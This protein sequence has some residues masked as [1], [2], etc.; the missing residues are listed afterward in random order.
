MSADLASLTLAFDGAVYA[1]IA[2][3]FASGVGEFWYLPNFE[4]Y[5]ERFVDHP[6][7]GIY[8]TSLW[9]QV[10]GSAFWT[11]KLLH[12]VL[13]FTSVF[14]IAELAKMH[15]ISPWLAVL[16]FV[17]MPQTTATF[18]GGYLESFVIT[19]SLL[20]VWALLRAWQSLGW[21][22]IYG[23]FVAAAVL[24]KGPVGLFT[25]TAPLGLWAV[26]R[27]FW[28]PFLIGCIALVPLLLLA[29][30]TFL[31]EGAREFV[32]QY[33]A[34]QVWASISGE[35]PVQE[36]RIDL[37]LWLL[38]HLGV[39]ILVAALLACRR[40]ALS[41]SSW[42]WV[43]LAFA[44]SLPL[45]ISARTYPHYITP[46]LP[47]LA[48]AAASALTP[49]KLPAW[50]HNSNYPIFATT[51]VCMVI[52]I[53]AWSTPGD[54][55]KDIN[56]A[57]EIAKFVDRLAFCNPQKGLRT[58]VYSSLYHGIRPQ[59]LERVDVGR[60]LGTLGI[61]CDEPPASNHVAIAELNRDLNL[62]VVHP[63]DNNSNK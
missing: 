35:R 14:V 20:A 15:S 8:M 63:A 55:A 27:Q 22:L 34:Q 45:L 32:E 61:L 49:V 52:A 57:R 10:F 3:L 17:V 37:L 56:G 6:P 38:T 42:L 59:P 23:A 50:V 7:L 9:M 13:F 33:W 31:N 41:K 18:T 4:T 1:S 26:H 47:F 19:W 24:T 16:F 60:G 58:R 30:L 5:P 11:P 46:V 53:Q 44:G 54:H 21:A 28:R 36:D 2:K 62:W 29:A 25:L 40:P 39:V 43:I 48:L 12:L 51:L